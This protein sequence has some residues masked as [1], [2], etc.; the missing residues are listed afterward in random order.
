MYHSKIEG[1]QTP[2]LA[3]CHGGQ[4]D[5]V[6]HK[7]VAM[8]VRARRHGT[9]QE[10]AKTDRLGPHSGEWHI[11]RLIVTSVVRIGAI[12][13]AGIYFQPRETATEGIVRATPRDFGSSDFTLPPAPAPA[14]TPVRA[15]LDSDAPATQADFGLLET[16]GPGENDRGAAIIRLGSGLIQRVAVDDWIDHRYR[17]IA[18]GDTAATLT[19]GLRTIALTVEPSPPI[20][21]DP[22]GGLPGVDFNQPGRANPAMARR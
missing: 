6:Q 1:D 2:A 8:Q 18:V 14:P 19:D 7:L 15:S 4:H 17:L 12:L 9:C 13:L 21:P 22:A 11:K 3:V 20:V 10:G 5:Q 16:E